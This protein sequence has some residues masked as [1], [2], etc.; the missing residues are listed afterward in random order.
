[1]EPFRQALLAIGAGE[2]AF[3]VEGDTVRAWR[4]A[5]VARLQLVNVPHPNAG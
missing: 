2:W 3:A 4:V 5:V 1:M